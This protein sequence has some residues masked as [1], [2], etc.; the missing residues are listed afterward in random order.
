MV[1]V[2][3]G[4]KLAPFAQNLIMKIS[5]LMVRDLYRAQIS[6]SNYRFLFIFLLV[7][8]VT[9]AGCQ[10]K[11]EFRSQ[12]PL[13]TPGASFLG[14]PEPA[15]LAQLAANPQVYLGKYLRVSGLFTPSED[16]VTCLKNIRGPEGRWYLADDNW[17]LEVSGYAQIVPRLQPGTPMTIDGVFTFYRG[18]LGCGKG[19]AQD[20]I[21]YLQ[22]IHIVEPNP[23]PLIAGNGDRIL[24]DGGNDLAAGGTAT[25][26]PTTISPSGVPTGNPTTGTPVTSTSTPSPTVPPGGTTVIPTA[27]NE[28]LVTPSPTASVPPVTPSDTPPKETDIPGAPTSTPVPPSPSPTVGSGYP[29]PTSPYP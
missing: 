10:A 5:R 17:R 9:L 28:V 2:F 14:L 11:G 18:P 29:T 12:T 26:T 20:S 19:A 23:L 21:W 8:M 3:P 15:T 25:L 22:A 7:V 16:A 4:R 27:T 6:K 24:F 1:G 13:A